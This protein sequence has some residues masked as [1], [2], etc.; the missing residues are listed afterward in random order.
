MNPK[1]FLYNT[2]ISVQPSYIAGHSLR[3]KIHL[4]C[5]DIN[6]DHC[7]KSVN[8]ELFFNFNLFYR[9]ILTDIW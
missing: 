5:I 2:A 3:Q 8:F 4:H 6:D 1:K 9:K 7:Y